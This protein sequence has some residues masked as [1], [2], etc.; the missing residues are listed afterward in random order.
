[1]SILNHKKP[2]LEE[3]YEFYADML[4]R[5]A[6]AQLGNDAD[7]QDVVHDVFIKYLTK[8]PIFLSDEHQK[9]WMIRVTINHCHDIARRTSI[10]K[11]LPLEEASHVTVEA[12]H[13]LDSLMDTLSCI[14]EKYRDTVI[15]H[16]LEGFSVQE[17]AKILGIS[18]SATKMRLSRAR[19]QLQA[20]RK[21]EDDVSRKRD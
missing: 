7:A 13:D 6:F 19:E 15:L 10:R 12:P 18:L 9:A 5:I 8:V 2:D 20:L 16:Y 17:T 3:I 1:M 11:T 21:E 14:P 4:Y